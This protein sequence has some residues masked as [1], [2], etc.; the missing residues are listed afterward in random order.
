MDVNGTRFQLLLGCADWARCTDENG[1]PLGLICDPAS[2]PPERDGS[3]DG[4]TVAWDSARHELTL[5][6]IP[7]TFASAPTD[8]PPQLSDRRGGG[9]D[10]FGSF[11]WISATARAAEVQSSGTGLTSTFWPG[12]AAATPDP[13]PGAFSAVTPTAPPQG[14]LLS[15]AAVT[16]DNFLVLG[17]VDVPG[18]LVFDLQAGGPP[19]QLPWPAGVDFS[20]FDM[21]A[22]PGGGVFVLDR[23]HGRAWELDR[24]FHVVTASVPSPPADAPGGFATLPGAPPPPTVPTAPAAPMAPVTRPITA[25]DATPVGD[26]AIAIAA[27]PAGGFLVLQRGGGEGSMIARYADGAPAG[28]AVAIAGVTGHDMALVA[29]QVLVV[30][31]DGDQAHAFALTETAGAPRL[32]PLVTF[33]PMREFGGKGLIAAGDQA[34]YDFDDRWIPLV[35]Q[36]RPRHVDQAAIVTPPFDSGLPGCTWHRLMLDARLPQG[37]SVAV[38]SKAAD[39]AE[40]LGAAAWLPEPDPRPRPTGCELPF[41][42]E[43]PY[44]TFE[45][46]FQNARGRHLMVKLEL[47]GDGR[48]TPAIRALRAWYPRFSYLDQYLPRVYRQDPDSASFLDRYLANVEGFYTAIED[49]IAAAQ[50]LLGADTAP[51]DALDWLAGWFALTLDPQWDENRRRVFLRNANRFFAARGT[52][53]GVEIALRFALEPCIDD[54]V[55]DSVDPTT[56]ATARI[57]EAYRT[58]RTPGVVFGDP[59]DQGIPRIVVATPN[60][61][62][63]QGAGVLEAGWLAFVGQAGLDGPAQYPISDP[64]GDASAPWSEFSAAALGF[65]PVIADPSTWSGFLSRRYPGIAAL[66]AAYGLT[67]AAIPAD[68]SDVPPPTALPADGG[69][70]LDWF[71][72]QSVVIPMATKAHTFT[73]LL[74]W[75]LHVADSDGVELDNTQLRDLATRVVNLQKP[76]HTTFAVKFFWAA[77]RIGDARIGDDTLLA[78][79]SRVPELVT[80][81]VLGTDYL[82]ETFL[83]GAAATDEIR[84]TVSPAPATS[85][86]AEETQ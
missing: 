18:L 79:G 25:Q 67:G 27:D 5:Q 71:Q 9:G 85:D 58:R 72:F 56:P 47:L 45:L 77:F 24:H 19:A 41:V 62:P 1:D 6:P 68:F 64:G 12:P 66:A 75:P 80:Q 39:D 53:R 2:S 37:T 86:D 82:G 76:A 7:F 81:A 30:D 11:Y 3:T 55:F 69:P 57:V 65:V 29:G 43:G 20:P 26:D 50:V 42:E 8:R 4:P 52:I 74:P 14:V 34:Y 51:G 70:L 15:G 48:S 10:S 59:T 13:R 44:G 17:V 46:L 84:R 21:A 49:Q 40:L 36:A 63:D 28:A 16:E 31:A 61:T 23:D 33:Y 35:A 22:R 38:W 83:G 32:E 78:S 73:V 60:W 54:T